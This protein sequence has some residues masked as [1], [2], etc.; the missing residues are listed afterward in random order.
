MLTPAPPHHSL[1]VVLLHDLS[2]LAL[3]AGDVE[4]NPGP[5][6]DKPQ[7]LGVDDEC[8]T[9]E[10]MVINS[11]KAPQI[12]QCFVCKLRFHATCKTRPAGNKTLLD[13]FLAPTTSA[14]FQW[15]C[16]TCKTQDEYSKVMD[17][18]NRINLLE[19]KLEHLEGIETKL[20]AVLKLL[21]DAPVNP[22][23]SSQPAPPRP[24]TPLYSDKFTAILVKKSG[25]ES[26]EE[27]HNKTVEMIQTNN[28][29]VLKTKVT[30]TGDTVVQ[31][32]NDNIANE[33]KQQLR[34]STPSA[35]TV[36]LKKKKVSISVVG[37]PGMSTEAV[38][39]D[40]L[41]K[42][43]QI[44]NMIRLHGDDHQI[45][46]NYV[47]PTRNKPEINQA[48]LT[49]SNTVRDII[50]KNNDRLLIGDV[51]CRV[52]SVTVH[53]RRCVKCQEFGH[54]HRVCPAQSASCA[55]CSESHETRDCPNTEKPGKNQKC[56]NCIRKG[57]PVTNHHGH[58]AS[59]PTCPLYLEERLKL[60][61]APL[62]S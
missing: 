61:K 6:N 34:L 14:N 54:W 48:N 25:E 52:Y 5:A 21:K 3:L 17:Q 9:C 37:V 18:A 11:D 22:A 43:P 49:V 4:V 8:A 1:H 58:R 46:V 44:N 35:E 13:K 56:I 55:I 27:T 30:S 20:D 28:L 39:A 41:T 62:N 16:D 29:Q 36:D 40:I 23:I 53:V 7:Q 15:F 51:C 10:I 32:P 42:N 19:A 26:S 2:F 45:T 59:S 50:A 12:I 47:K 24:V 33:F 60:S 31:F 57:A 38:K